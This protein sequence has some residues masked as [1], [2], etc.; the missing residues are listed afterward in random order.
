MDA[1]AVRS[2][3]ADNRF[4]PGGAII[5][6]LINEQ[7]TAQEVRLIGEAG[8]QIGIVSI[9]EARRAAEEAELD[10]VL[11]APQANPPVCKI[12][13]FGKFRYEQARKE[14]EAKKKQKVIEV[15]EVRF[16]PNIDANDMK[17]KANMARKFIEHGDRVKVS[18]RFR[19]RELSRM[20]ERKG[21][22][23]DFAE[24]LSDVAKIDKEP[25]AEGRNMVMFLSKKS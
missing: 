3:F 15:K 7:I 9:E 11:I 17:T 14:K 16:T 4:Y 6:N 5:N 22:L 2:F 13:D 1:F 10:L 18:L 23:Y 12:I 21:V 24:M 8:Q 19:G 20:Q 25:K